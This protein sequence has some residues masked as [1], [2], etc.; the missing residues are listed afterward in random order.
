MISSNAE[1]KKELFSIEQKAIER[2]SSSKEIEGISQYLRQDWFEITGIKA[3]DE[4][5]CVDVVKAIGIK[6]SDEEACV[7]VV[8]AIGELLEV[9]PVPYEDIL[10]AHPSSTYNKH[11]PTK[12][13]CRVYEK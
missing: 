6:A 9:L 13:Y 3:S 1:L 10:I 4:E 2:N 5:A 8:K 7:D 11:W 12:N